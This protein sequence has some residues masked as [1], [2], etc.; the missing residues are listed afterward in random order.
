VVIVQI[1]QNPLGDTPSI[2][3]VIAS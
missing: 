3:L 2:L 1:L